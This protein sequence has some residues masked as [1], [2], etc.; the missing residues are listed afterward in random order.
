[1]APES[2]DAVRHDTVS[3]VTPP[4]TPP[5]QE[6]DEVTSAQLERALDE[7]KAVRREV[8]WVEREQSVASGEMAAGEYLVTYVITPA[9]DYYDLE[10]AQSK[11]PAHHTTVLP[12]SAQVAVVIRDAADGRM[13]PGLTVHATLRSESAGRESIAALP[14]G[15]HPVLNRYSENMMLPD[16][17]FTLTLRIDT[18]NFRRHDRVNGDRFKR[19]VTARFTHI[20]VS[21]DSLAVAAQHLARGDS[22]LSVDL[23]RGEGMGVDEPLTALLRSDNANGT[24]ARSGDYRVAVVMQPAR[25][26][27]RSGKGKLTYVDTDSSV[28]PVTH[29][30]VSIRDATT[31]RFIPGLKVR[32]TILDSRNKEVDTYTLPFTWHPWMNHYGLNVPAPKAGRYTVRVRAEAPSFR[33]YGSTALKTF[34]KAVDVRLI[35]VRVPVDEKKF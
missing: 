23:A 22:R 31:G 28:G 26:E 15:W 12:G 14:Y 25:G 33:R 21:P 6:S 24:Q 8:E 19:D 32:A 2:H 13:V 29:L 4:V 30:D 11:L 16:N 17:P 27:W 5:F 10:A 3:S 34:N 20:T 18:P 9:D 7:G 35:G 1:V